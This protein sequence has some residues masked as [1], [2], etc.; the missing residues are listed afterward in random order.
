M[1]KDKVYI[2]G[3]EVGFRID[4]LGTR[5]KIIQLVSGETVSIDEN[6]I[7]K[8]IEQEKATIPKFVADWIE[9]CKA[10]EKR[11][12]TALLYTPEKVNSWVDNSENQEL[13]ARAW[14]DGYEVEK[15]KKYIVTLKS[16]GQKLYYHTEDEDYIF[17][18]Y[19]GVFYS[20]YH[21]KTDLEENG[22]SWV[23]DCEGLEVQEV[24]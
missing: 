7:Y 24:E 22:M 10:K 6:F 21:T 11:L 18:S 12:L 1:N 15:E 9:E 17:S 19:D 2:E 14:L 3:Y 5:E 16:S 20:G 23:F 8:S 13:F 4:T